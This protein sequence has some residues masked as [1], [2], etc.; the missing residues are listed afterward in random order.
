MFIKGS[1]QEK[2]RSL[3]KIKKK[4]KWNR[5]KEK[6]SVTEGKTSIESVLQIPIDLQNVCKLNNK[7]MHFIIT[8]VEIWLCSDNKAI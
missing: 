5:N 6:I 7:V 2:K 4:L 1:D 3:N 8:S